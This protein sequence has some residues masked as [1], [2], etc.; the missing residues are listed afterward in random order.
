MIRETV[1]IWRLRLEIALFLILFAWLYPR[2]FLRAVKD[3]LWE[4]DP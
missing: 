1:S 3:S 4:R 2:L